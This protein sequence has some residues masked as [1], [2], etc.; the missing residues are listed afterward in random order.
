MDSIVNEAE[1]NTCSIC[2][3]EL[4]TCTTLNCGHKFHSICVNKLLVKNC[5]L[6]RIKINYNILL[7]LSYTIAMQNNKNLLYILK[8]YKIDNGDNKFLLY[9]YG[10]HPSSEKIMTEIRNF[11][12]IVQY[13][14]VVDVINNKKVK[15]KLIAA[16]IK[17]LPVIIDGNGKS[18]SGVNSL[19]FIRNIIK[20]VSI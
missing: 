20:H 8:F 10:I 2:L 12:P 18:Y 15:E 13:F 4:N 16:G 3:E 9:I 7:H 17:K 5:P 1:E 6:C 19:G 11:P 14:K